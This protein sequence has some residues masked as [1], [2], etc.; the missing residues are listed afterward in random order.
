MRQLVI[1]YGNKLIGYLDETGMV[2][3]VPFKIIA[4]GTYDPEGDQEDKD[5]EAREQQAK[6][7][8]DVDPLEAAELDQ[9]QEGYVQR[10][11]QA[12][13]PGGQGADIRFRR[14]GDPPA[15]QPQ[16]KAKH[17]T[18]HRTKSGLHDV[19]PIEILSEITNETFTKKIRVPC[20]GGLQ[21]LAK[22]ET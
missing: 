17:R 6:I 10:Q 16:T 3:N 11:Q 4:Q 19:P 12:D 14:D 22:R 21:R 15:V 20:I 5:F 1:I 8:Y 18:H 9:C 2:E 13:Q 7:V